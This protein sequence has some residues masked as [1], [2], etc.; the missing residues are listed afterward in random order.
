M[1]KKGVECIFDN[2][3]IAKNCHIVFLCVLPSQ[4]E[5]VV[6]DIKEIISTNTIIYSL[7]RSIPAKRLRNLLNPDSDYNIIKPNYEYVQDV[8]RFYSKWN[9]RLETLETFE[10]IETINYTNPLNSINSK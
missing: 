6:E 7:V 5:D 2:K 4:L 9:Y 8:E 1:K 10:S 3:V